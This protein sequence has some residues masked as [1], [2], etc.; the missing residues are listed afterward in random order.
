MPQLRLLLIGSSVAALATTA[1]VAQISAQAPA[2]QRSAPPT[3][4]AAQGVQMPTPTRQ[5][6][7]Q[8]TLT[9]PAPHDPLAQKRNAD[10]QANAGHG[11]PKKGTKGTQAQ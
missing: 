5:A 3:A 7:A 1:A 9:A 11:D 10:A 8:Q 4:P 6:Q 2:T